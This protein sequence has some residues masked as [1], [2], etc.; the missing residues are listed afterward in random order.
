MQCVPNPTDRFDVDA[1]NRPLA[2]LQFASADETHRHIARHVVADV[3]RRTDPTYSADL[4]AFTGL[5]TSFGAIGRIAA[6]GRL[7]ARSRI[8]D[9]GIWWFSFFMYYASGP[10]PARLRQFLALADAGVLRFI[11]ADVSVTG[12]PASGRFVAR[13]TSH[14]D[15][16]VGTAFVDARIATPSVSRTTDVLLRRLHERGEVV[17]EVVSDGDGWSANS[18]KVVVTG[19]DLRIVR[20]DG[21]AHPRRHGVGVFTNRP[22]AGTFARPRTN[23]ASFRQNDTIARSI[24]RTLANVRTAVAVPSDTV[25]S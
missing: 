14:P 19:N 5:L 2:A 16:V 10:P 3:A 15:S 6:S 20:R 22:A 21:S 4:G 7:T 11:G 9:F 24:L 18:G 23:A 8:D 13:S 17:E 25:A 1:L 12:D